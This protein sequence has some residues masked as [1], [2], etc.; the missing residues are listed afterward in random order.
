LSNLIE[1]GNSA[2]RP[3]DLALAFD[4]AS[5]ELVFEDLGNA[6]DPTAF[7]EPDLVRGADERR[8]GGLGIHLVRRMMDEVAYSRVADRNRLVMR[9]RL[10]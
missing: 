8:A 7:A 10:A 4:G 3:V 9:K 1:H 6:F 5:I 2:G